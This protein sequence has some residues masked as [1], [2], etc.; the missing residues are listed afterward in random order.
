MPIS[1]LDVI[2]AVGIFVPHLRIYSVRRLKVQTVL[3]DVVRYMWRR[4]LRYTRQ[5]PCACP[6]ADLS[7]QLAAHTHPLGSIL[8]AYELATSSS[9]R[10]KSS[11]RGS[12]T[13]GL[14][15][16]TPRTDEAVSGT[17]AAGMPPARPC[18]SA[19]RQCIAP[20]RGRCLPPSMHAKRR[21]ALMRPDSWPR[22]CSCCVRAWS[23]RRS[24]IASATFISD[25]SG[26]CGPPSSAL[27]ACI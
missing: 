12:T 8:P 27:A 14:C 20:W 13:A 26:L 9:L 15:H 21:A 3:A 11:V 18:V 24:D 19:F 7:G 16:A 2:S 1:V 10:H 17:C 22:A 25:R 6:C 5:L 23:T 4:W